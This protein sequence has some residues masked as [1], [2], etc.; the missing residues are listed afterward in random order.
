MQLSKFEK[1]RSHRGYH[2]EAE[3]EQQTEGDEE[4]AFG[5]R[6]KVSLLDQHSELKKKAEGITIGL[7][8]FQSGESSILSLSTF[9]P[10]IQ[11]IKYQSWRSKN[12]KRSQ[13]Y[14]ISRRQEH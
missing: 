3:P 13:F 9:P 10:N 14:I 4:Q 2:V 7:I 6:S 5:T 8:N 12:V 11:P 1:Y